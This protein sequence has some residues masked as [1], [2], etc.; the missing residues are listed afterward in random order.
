MVSMYFVIN[1]ANTGYSPIKGF[2]NSVTGVEGVILDE[3]VDVTDELW[4][5]ELKTNTANFVRGFSHI[6]SKNIIENL[7]IIFAVTGFRP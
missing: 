1:E 7:E 6:D 5:K 4:L 2:K 3:P